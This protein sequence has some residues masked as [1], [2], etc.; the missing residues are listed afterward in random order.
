[1]A[2]NSMVRETRSMSEAA[3]KSGSRSAKDHNYT[4]SDKSKV[5][6]PSSKYQTAVKL[7]D[8]GEGC[9]KSLERQKHLLC[10]FCENSYCQSCSSLSK[11]TFDVIHSCGSA[12]DMVLLSLYSRHPR[13]S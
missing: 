12:S 13:G 3:E 8:S 10:I 6:V 4:K 7:N 2:T 5:P 11:N 1:M 9:K